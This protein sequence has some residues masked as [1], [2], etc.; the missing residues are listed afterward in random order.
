[1][2]FQRLIVAVKACALLFCLLLVA[3]AA[4]A[5]TTFDVKANYTKLERMI[6]MR[7]GV[8]L[9]TVIYVPK[10]ASQKYPIMLNRTP[11]SVGPY[12]PDKYKEAIGPS[13]AFEREGYIFAY[14]DVR[15]KF[16]SEGEFVNMRPQLDSKS[17][18][19]QIDESSDTY[20]TIDWLV[21]NTPNNNGRVGMWGI[22][23]PGFYTSAGSID[24]HPALKAV[25]PQAPISDWFTSDDFHHN[26]AFLL[27]D[28][29]AFMS[30]F[31][32][33]RP[34][35]T[36]EWPP[37]FKY[38][39]PDAYKF[40]LELGPLANANAL[41][42]KNNVAFWNEMM[43]HSTYDSFWQARNLRPHLKNIRAAVMTVGGLFDAE[44]LF[45]TF[46]TYHAIE[47]Q[48]PNIFN[49]L[50]IGPWYHGGWSR[51]EGDHLGNVQFGSK[52][53][54]FY[55]EQIELPFF[56]HYLKDKP[57]PNLPEAYVFE[58]GS[59]QWRTYEQWPPRNTQTQS[60]YFQS[61]GKLSFAPPPSSP[62]QAYDE[63]ISDP[64]RPVPYIDQILINRTRE[65]MTDD[66]RFAAMRPDV[67]VYQ[68]DALTEDTTIVG[69][70][71]VSLNV[72]TS[73]TD[74]DFV[75]KLIDVYPNDAPDNTPNPMNVKMGGYEMLVRA[76]VMRARFRNSYERPE[77][78]T[79]NRAT[80][81][82]F[83]LADVSHT[84]KKGHR[85]MAQIQ[86]SWFPLVDRNP[87]KFVDIYKATAAD[88]QRATQRVY[89][90][91]RDGSHL[92]LS[93]IKK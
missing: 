24:S 44:D 30:V 48:N 16:M 76:E 42:F 73:G 1:M 85:I 38:G 23:Y 43:E 66:Q 29:F 77:P 28:A 69:P 51:S 15:G 6:R 59:N 83:K 72:S 20:D 21:K 80:R 5:Q 60:L 78:M 64:A 34:Q 18:P 52:T 74:S 39:T 26:G 79:P 10:D 3:P 12:G 63:Y 70:I 32:Q 90:A 57:L 19:Q 13:V 58:T 68:T 88:F 14:Q 61:N 50:V 40:Y 36:P 75:V 37:S 93:V 89:R 84:F 46:N 4:C 49:V 31:G 11:Y 41:Y 81:V 45:G 35:P 91:G 8:S 53:S 62:A 17:G 82:A 22:S 65:Y 33:P 86:S 54:V 9:F 2:R 7:D 27:M 25:S 47:Q 67:L 87:Q 56:N 55:R 71:N 92:D